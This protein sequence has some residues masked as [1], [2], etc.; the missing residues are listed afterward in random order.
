MYLDKLYYCR[1]FFQHVHQHSSYHHV[2]VR[3]C[4]SCA[5]ASAPH[6]HKSLDTHSML[7]R[8]PIGHQ[9]IKDN[10]TF[11][12]KN[13]FLHLYNSSVSLVYLCQSLEASRKVKVLLYTIFVMSMEY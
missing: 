5:F 10:T 13:I 8:I 12:H 3:V 4:Y 1:F 7:S 9:L 6:R 2:E 11:M